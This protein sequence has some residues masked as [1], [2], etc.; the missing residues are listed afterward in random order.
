LDPHQVDNR[1]DKDPDHIQKVP[2]HPKAGEPSKGGVRNIK[3]KEL[4]NEHYQPGQSNTYVQA[5]GAHKGKVGGEESAFLPAVALGE[6]VGKFG[7]FN[8]NEESS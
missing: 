8:G 4:S 5:V 6:E 3:D 7:Q 1:K 2:K